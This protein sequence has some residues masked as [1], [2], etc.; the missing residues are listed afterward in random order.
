MREFVVKSKI[1]RIP[2]PPSLDA[3]TIAVVFVICFSSVEVSKVRNT[4]KNGKL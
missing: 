1:L 2:S 3:C 4:A